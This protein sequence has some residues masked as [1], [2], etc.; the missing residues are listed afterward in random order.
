MNEQ[1]ALRTLSDL[2]GWTYQAHSEFAWLRLMSKFKYDAYQG[3]EPGMRFFESLISWLHQFDTKPDREVAYEFLKTRLIFFSKNEVAH[4]VHRFYPIVR[5]T[6]SKA[7]AKEHQIQ[8][9][10]IWTHPSTKGLYEVSLRKS[11][12]VGLSD[13]AM[14][15][16]FRRSN[17]GKLSNEQIVVA[18]EIS[19]P[20][21]KGMV[22]KLEEDIKAKHWN[23]QAMFQH[24]FLID[25][26]TASG[27]S[28]ITPKLGGGW[29][30]KINKFITSNEKYLSRFLENPC[31]LHVHHYLAT[32]DAKVTVEAYAAQ[33]EAQHPEFNI[34]LTFGHII[35]GQFKITPQEDPKFYALLT[36]HYDPGVET[37]IS[38]TVQ[39]GY[40]NCSLPVVLEHNTP[41]N[42]V[43]LIWAESNGA[44]ALPAKTLKP[45]F[46]RRTRH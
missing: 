29:S 6:L 25:D 4:L 16:V 40:K 41:N 42:T 36:N 37:T 18:H 11:M 14:M 15:D 27:T 12:F 39:F 38:G 30:G 35:E 22:E 23:T 2:L 32:S 3:Y 44:V 33:L 26:F 28:L 10:E 31:L 46:R 5:D 9:Y 21:W 34:D 13:G 7:I 24:V 20:K 1:L 8:P 17:E 45:L 43:G 19:E